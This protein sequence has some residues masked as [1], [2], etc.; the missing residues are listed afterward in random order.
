MSFRF[1]CPNLLFRLFQKFSQQYIKL[2]STKA[3]HGF[4]STKEL[5]LDIDL[6]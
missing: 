2:D 4:D 3:R 6:N 5:C 1:E